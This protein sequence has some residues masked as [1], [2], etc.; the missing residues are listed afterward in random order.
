MSSIGEK[1]RLAFGGKRRDVVETIRFSEVRSYIERLRG[2]G[3]A[4]RDYS[5][6]IR[7]YDEFMEKLDEVKKE[8]DVLRQNGEKRFTRIANEILKGISSMDE[9]DLSSFREFYSDA[10]QA[11]Q[12]LMKIPGTIQRKAL[13]YENGKEAVN[14]LNSL[15]KSFKNLRKARSETLGGNSTLNHHGS[16]LKKCREL[17][18]AFSRK[19]ELQKELESLEEEK[20]ER[21][22]NLEETA[23]NL[24]AA[25]S[26]IESEEMLET[27]KRITSLDATVRK[28]R[29]DLRINLRRGRRPISKILYS[30][31]RRLFQFYQYFAEYPLENVNDRF[32]EMIATLEKEEVNLGEKERRKIDDFV[33]FS[34][35]RLVAM[36]GEYEDARAKKRELEESYSKISLRSK[37][38][39]RNL[40]LQKENAENDFA[41]TT[42]R[43]EEVETEKDMLESVIEKDVMMLEK[44]LSRIGNVK[45]KIEFP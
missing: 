13:S 23:A 12:S 40:E 18:D 4:S 26:E 5:L 30:K 41:R 20:E 42:K 31:D 7:N 34:R 36:I 9:F 27:K 21:R 45:I 28:I 15:L 10:A 14:A 33:S 19:A 11:V 44:T 6:L 16:A 32:W 17:E 2:S 29:S 25:Q 35:N 3:E 8:L 24:Q 1:I 39:L 43:L 38:L 37:D 22:R